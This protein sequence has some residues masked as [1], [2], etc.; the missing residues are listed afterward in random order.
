MVKRRPRAVL[1]ALASIAA[2]SIGCEVV[3]G[4]E[5]ARVDPTLS[6]SE[7]GTGGAS[8]SGSDGGSSGSKSGGGSAGSDPSGGSGNAN[9]SGGSGANTGSG[10][11]AGAPQKTLCEAYCEELTGNCDSS[12]SGSTL[13]QYA[14]LSQCLAACTLF[15]RGEPGDRGVNTIE[16]RMA[17]ARSAKSEPSFECPRAGPVPGENGC[18]TP[19][20]AYC[21]LMM[22]ACNEQTTLGEDGYLP[23][24]TI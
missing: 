21:T 12:G 10:G 24:T 13:R 17:R 1:G 3:L 11:T 5:Q 6:P 14:D 23:L 20:D 2:L 19:C 7:G 16:C 4:I 8:A 15:P 18:G 9:T 22:G